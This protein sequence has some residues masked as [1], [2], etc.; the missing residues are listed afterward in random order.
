MGAFLSLADKI[1]SRNNSFDPDP[2]ST[3]A[4]HAKT[5][6]M[7]IALTDEGGDLS[8]AALIH[9]AQ[10]VAQ[11]L[12]ESGVTIGTVVAVSFPQRRHQIVSL[13]ALWYLG[14]IYLPL[15]PANP[16]ARVANILGQAKPALALTDPATSLAAGADQFSLPRLDLPKQRPTL[17]T[18]PA[19]DPERLAYIIFTSGSTGAP[20]GVMLRHRGLGAV[21]AAQASAFAPGP[22][23]SI[24]QFASFGFDAS[25]FEILLALAHGARL[26][27]PPPGPP[28]LAE[29]LTDFLTV[30][31]ISLATLPPAALTG[32][33]PPAHAKLRA[34]ILAGEAPHPA[35]I[36][37]W[38]AQCRVFN[39]YGPTEAT[40]WSSL[41]PC[42]PDGGSTN[43]SDAPVPIGWPIEGTEFHIFDA[44]GT[45]I[46][47]GESGELYLGGIGIA[48][49]YIGAPDLTADRFRPHPQHAGEVL[50]RTGD[51]VRRR[52]D[53]AYLF[54]GRIDYQIKLRGYRIEPGEIEAQM[55]RLPD[56]REALVTLHGGTQLTAYYTAPKP[57]P[58][59]ALKAALGTTLPAWMLPAAFVW[60]AR[61]PLTINGKIDRAALPPPDPEAV[62]R[63]PYAPPQ[64]PFEEAVVAVWSE[65]LGLSGISRHDDFLSLG[66]NS[67]TAAQ[68][69]GRLRDRLNRLVNIGDI[70]AA[71]V[72]ADL[73]LR[74]QN[75]PI[76]SKREA[77][78]VDF[79]APAPLPLSEQQKGVWL[80]EK[81]SPNLLAYNAQSVIRWRGKLD[82]A[83]LRRALDQI[84][85][86]HEIFRTAFPE[87]ASGTP[88]QQVYP[89]AQAALTEV[90]LR[91]TADPIA[92]L[93]A[94]VGDS[95]KRP[96]DLTRLPLVRWVLFTLAPDDYALLHI[97]HHLVHDGW[98]A[99]LF[100]HELLALYGQD[101]SALPPPPAQYRNY[102]A[103]QTSAEAEARFAEDLTYWTHKLAGAP[104]VLELPQDFPRPQQMSFRGRQIRHEIPAALFA[105][106]EA[107]CRNQHVTPYTV[108]LA[109]FQLLLSRYTG[110]ED[111][112]TGS[113]AA[114]RPHQEAEGML[115]MFVN[116]IVLRANLSGDLSF[117][118]L[119]HRV[120]A[121]V[122]EA[123]DHQSLPFER[124]VR[125]LQPQRTTA[126][127]PI[128]QV[129]FSF[130]NSALPPLEQADFSLSLFEAYSNDSAKFDLEVVILPRGQA[131]A[132]TLTLLWTYA[133][134][135]FLPETID[136][137]RRA[138]A[139]LLE[140]CLDDPL[141]ALA[142]LPVAARAERALSLSAWNETVA[143]PHDPRPLPVRFA[144]QAA[145]T[146]DAIALSLDGQSLTYRQ[147]EAQS[148]AL[149]HR[150]RKL[151]VGPE[152]V[153]ALCLERSFDLIV[154]ILGILKAGG[155][156]LPLDPASPVERLAF[157]L[158]DA[159]PRALLTHAETRD[160]VT[161]AQATLR[162]PVAL[163]GLDTPERVTAAT[164]ETAETLPVILAETLAYIIYTSG[165][166]GQPKG[167]LVEHRQATRLF[168]ATA[169]WFGFSSTDV[170]SLFHSIAFDFSVWEVWGALLYGGRLEIVPKATAQVPEI[171]YEC[172]CRAGVT[173]L[174]QT[175]SAFLALMAAQA[176]SPTP[177]RLRTVI[178]GGE[179]LD[180]TRLQPWYADAR[181][182]AVQL[183]N[184]YGI[185]ET[186]VHVTYRP[187]VPED[188]QSPPINGSP[189]GKK[190]PD[191][192]LYV[193]DQ[194]GHPA[195]IGAP[196]ELYIGGAGVARGYLNRPLLTAERFL[197]SPFV[198][199]DRLYRSGD[200]AR[201]NPDGSIDY[202]GRN[203]FQ[204]K[205]RGFRI[206]LGEIEARLKQYPGVHDALV[207]ARPDPF[208]DA[209]LVAYCKSPAPLASA[210]LRAALAESLP[211]YMIP[212]AFVTLA[213]FPLTA[214]GKL[215]RH[216]LP[217]PE[218]TT[219]DT[220]YA[221]PATEIER[222]ITAIWAEV[223]GRAPIGRHD[224]FFA[225]GGHSLLAMRV[226]AK[227]R[228]AGLK[229]DVR[230]LF[231]HATP[232]RLAT[233]LETV[234]PVETVPPN[235][236][237]PDTARLTPEI[238]PLVTL[239]QAD[240]DRIVGQTLGGLSAIQDIYPLTPFQEGILYHHLL[241]PSSD[242]YLLWTVMR[243]DSRAALDAYCQGFQ[244]AI[245]RHDILRTGLYWEGISQPVQIVYRTADLPITDVALPP[246]DDPV[247]ALIAAVNPPSL[248]FDLRRPPLVR[249][250][251]ASE[252]GDRWLVLKTFHHAIDD[253]TSLKQLKAEIAALASGQSAVLPPPIPFRNF[254]F[255]AGRNADTPEARAFFKTLL[256]DVTETAAPFGLHDHHG[257]GS[258]VQVDRRWLGGSA[259]ARLRAAAQAHRLTVASLV[260]CAFASALAR[261][262][263]PTAPT[264]F[265]TVLF[266]R[267]GGEVGSDYSLGPFINTLPLRLETRTGTCAD[268]AAEAHRRLSALLRVEH[269]APVIA[270]Q[271]SGIPSPA[272]LY[273]A[274]LN[275]RHARRM[276][277]DTVLALPGLTDLGGE[278]RSHYPLML[279]V[280]DFGDD[281]RLTTHLRAPIAPGLFADMA[282]AALNALSGA[283]LAEPERPIASLD[284]FPS[285]L[286]G[287]LRREP[288]ATASGDTLADRLTAVSR[289]MAARQ[290]VVAPDG[291]LTYMA[292]HAK[293]DRLAQ[294][295][296]GL[297]VGPDQRVALSFQ[298]GGDMIVAILA[299]WKAGGAY[300]PLD[301]EYPAARLAHC[302][303]DSAPVVVL[304]HRPAAAVV[305]AAIREAGVP[306]PILWLD[307]PDAAGQPSAPLPARPSAPENLAYVIYTS[308]ST[309]LPKG[310][311]VPQRG[312]LALLD[313]AI[314]LFEIHPNDRCLAVTS[315]SFD[316]SVLEIMAPLLVGATVIVAPPDYSAPGVL[317]SLIQSQHVTV[318][319]MVPTALRL[320]LEAPD[321]QACQSLRALLCGGEAMPPALIGLA[322]TR[323]PRAQL[324]NLYGPTETTI[325]SFC[326]RCEAEEAPVPIGLPI[327]G[328]RA[329]LL[330]PAG[331]PVPPGAVG[332]IAIGGLGVARGYL[333]R[334]DLTKER[335][336][337]DPLFPTE[338]LY[339]TGDLGRIRPDGAWEF[340]GRQDLQVKLRGFR[341][342][343]G[344]I[345]AR[346]AAFP[347][348][349]GA[350]VR[351]LP[352]PSGEPRL[353]ATLA[354]PEPVSVQAI[355]SFLAETLPPYMRPNLIQHLPA[356][357][358]TP[359]GK[360][361]RAALPMPDAELMIPRATY[362]PPETPIE[363]AIATIWAE[364]LSVEAVGLTDSFFDLG[365]HSLLATR[366]LTRLRDLLGVDLRLRDLFDHPTVGDLTAFLFTSADFSDAV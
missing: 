180:V 71:P 307:D 98:S 200:L 39:A 203:D 366:I 212:A 316:I 216:A 232:A 262:C 285:N 43:E 309:G 326:Y 174:N 18:P 348:V 46:P 296:I 1:N 183:V 330:D 122:A 142:Q 252:G 110:M 222:Q 79:A 241:T 49:G 365:G 97:E 83:A 244:A 24:L 40:I 328:T 333:N 185:T 342:E 52:A 118:D 31:G 86:R 259:T 293:A 67:L 26:V 103:W 217:A 36:N 297:G 301:P 89:N 358:L 257:D 304:S 156:Y 274:L 91:Q 25:L 350:A 101:S 338:R 157:I 242:P 41:Y 273:A 10:G 205:I 357:P 129:G 221:P 55:C 245:A 238:L 320:L 347:G 234:H 17:F 124:L 57:Q 45:P 22:G 14:A 319:Q 115:G 65:I 136:R 128:F 144:D 229:L 165:S 168:D 331:N 164:S 197:P 361:D 181:N 334:P 30:E 270:Q 102:V 308:G 143:P 134:D 236:L 148:T 283:L 306:L 261:C 224:D 207:I 159:K 227:L 53:G 151:G 364:V 360:I 286:W 186:T 113:A 312:V 37:A 318:A 66:G 137:V 63:H 213:L 69:V 314:Q 75:A 278:E 44:N 354:A 198:P 169:S 78:L 114:N 266:G 226:A 93:W 199:G 105:R 51:R 175:P 80:L 276:A 321:V 81:L 149:A 73:A 74:L 13:L 121:T 19:Y 248:Q 119:V 88:F 220:A 85:A 298:R 323:L 310:V 187:L 125:A 170:W 29:A 246:S 193:L 138:Y 289:T 351:L 155:A 84:I 2:L 339:L 150:L 130:H 140:A 147:L 117:I 82:R 291:S 171:F 255:R 260:H 154:G 123:Y 271:M 231:S 251:C 208:G 225:L 99:N 176:A 341:L 240:L 243:F 20:K 337:P 196:G 218:L 254:V 59:Q 294:R 290:A 305:T 133:A 324:F 282:V 191:L 235:L 167:V 135:L 210:D 182:Q 189:I 6:P 313:W 340:L 302:L 9:E 277:D 109:A 281:M 23:D 284:C 250:F 90:D 42:P 47:E 209:Q 268:A 48:A 146:P 355:Q 64:T 120:H 327:T 344:E 230:Q 153:V 50:Y 139:D 346:L 33:C 95:V 106:I 173:V 132:R 353:V 345:E 325:W 256:A 34:V 194:A 16:P 359:N 35:L 311:M 32:L 239:P 152:I 158:D 195:P 322:R 204:V 215:D 12:A 269:T 162:E 160:V 54:L 202:L 267:L 188:C 279:A 28:P 258:R 362:V 356:L 349:R 161:A 192:R 116:S 5:Q 60:L 264:V 303:R 11:A 38:S 237:T 275:Y 72:V 15:D 3:I 253:N 299:V 141:K 214:N 166:T 68:S 211:D 332:E 58:P 145:R 223:L 127:N 87:D 288:L 92:A 131:E 8:Y 247:A 336:H 96:F 315:T 329:Y 249:L 363:Q 172:L 335:F 177:H 21:I 233:L 94:E 300:V 343:L 263:G 61:F 295:L 179:A 70:F 352:D 27:L 190:I 228:Q 184:M 317:P 100:L 280:D 108:L 126:R 206:E 287:A 265:G 62:I 272:P 178:F 107:F 292:L 104:Q 201:R 76:V 56:I 7:A 111:F 163:V 77:R 4:A 219:S 112:V